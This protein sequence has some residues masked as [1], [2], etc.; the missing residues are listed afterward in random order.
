MKFV[1]KYKKTI[2][3]VLLS[4]GLL[5]ICCIII[6]WIALY[7]SFASAGVQTEA[8]IS[9]EDSLKIF[10]LDESIENIGG[11]NLHVEGWLDWQYKLSFIVDYPNLVKIHNSIA[12]KDTSST[13]DTTYFYDEEFW[14]AEICLNDEALTQPTKQDIDVSEMSYA[15]LYECMIQPEE[16]GAIYQVYFY[17]GTT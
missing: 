11:Y 13:L 2:L 3:T 16:Q 4:F 1:K 5:A 14:S 8:D 12:T 17:G 15:T 10:D 6:F 9:F 7:N